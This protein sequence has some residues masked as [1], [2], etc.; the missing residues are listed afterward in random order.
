MDFPT[1]NDGIPPSTSSFH[2]AAE[3]GRD[4]ANLKDLSTETLAALDNSKE[5]RRNSPPDNLSTSLEIPVVGN[6]VG[7]VPKEVFTVYLS[8]CSEVGDDTGSSS[9]NYEAVASGSTSEKSSYEDNPR[10]L[11]DEL[12]DIYNIFQRTSNN[13]S[14]LPFLLRFM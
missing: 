4:E 1:N 2:I 13:P 6:T 10:Y 11:D 12:R 7:E 8:S 9:S 3:I 5:P 14:R